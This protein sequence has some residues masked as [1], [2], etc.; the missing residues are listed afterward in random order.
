MN[1][2]YNDESESSINGIIELNSQSNNEENSKHDNNIIED[3]K[4]ISSK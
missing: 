4:T 1:F 3:F 2:I